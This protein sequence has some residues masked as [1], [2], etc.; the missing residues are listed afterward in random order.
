M[1]TTLRK[2]INNI[3]QQQ[4]AFLLCIIL[5]LQT[6]WDKSEVFV[7]TKCIGQ[8]LGISWEHDEN[9]L[10]TR[11]NPKKSLLKTL[12]PCPKFLK[13]IGPIMCDVESSHW[14]HET[15]TSKTI[16]YHFHSRGAPIAGHST[17]STNHVHK[18]QI[19]LKFLCDF[20]LFI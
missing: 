7:I 1:K 11:K 10:G 6:T 19:C 3:Q 15:F 4:Q 12:S 20:N 5:G 8:P 9:T 17:P 14:L 2:S 18:E 16:C 13:K